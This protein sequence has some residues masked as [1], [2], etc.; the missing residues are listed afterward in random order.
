MP[1]L[2]PITEKDFVETQRLCEYRSFGMLQLE[3]VID[4]NDGAEIAHWFRS[5]PLALLSLPLQV[6]FIVLLSDWKH[7]LRDFS[8]AVFWGGMGQHMK[9]S[10]R[11]H[12]KRNLMVEH[13]WAFPVD[14]N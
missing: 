8:S 2:L 12:E 6:R 7:P 10:D 11:M 14:L 13:L 3:A 5:L 4:W 1:D 9:D